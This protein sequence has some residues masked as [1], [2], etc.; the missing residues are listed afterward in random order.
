MAKFAVTGIDDLAA[1]LK[2]LGLLDNSELV[3]GML[4]AG[5]E[6]VADE[7]K[8]GIESTVKS[9]AAGGRGTGEMKDS[10]RPAKGIK[11]IDGASAKDIYPQG[12]DSKGVRN[13]EKAF[14][15][16]Y[17]KSNANQPPTLF[18]DA[19]EDA[20]ENKAISAMEDVFN[21]YLEKEGF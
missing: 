12:K 2:R 10:V 17:G 8:K 1:D 6:I 11:T 19:V 15:L 7:W 3:S 20:A 13:A 5:A 18:V 21:N 16:H 14:I 4:E 9:K